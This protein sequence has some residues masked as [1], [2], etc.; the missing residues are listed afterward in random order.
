MLEAF[1]LLKCRLLKLMGD[2]S[3]VMVSRLV[4]YGVQVIHMAAALR[5]S[6]IIY[7]AIVE[8]RACSDSVNVFGTPAQ[9]RVILAG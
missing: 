1:N 4:G 7:V 5:L 6:H 9:V 3:R 2:V 8:Y